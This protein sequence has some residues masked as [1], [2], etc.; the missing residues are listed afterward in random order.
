MELLHFLRDNGIDSAN[1]ADCYFMIKYF[2]SDSDGKLNYSDFMQILMPCD[3]THLRA[4]I[5]QR[6]NYTV[7]KTE[8]LD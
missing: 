8:F 1:E 5:A 3:N 4:Q 2:D 7:K 6:Q